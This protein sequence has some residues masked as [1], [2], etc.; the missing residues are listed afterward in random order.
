[1]IRLTNEW[2]GAAI[3]GRH[4]SVRHA[5]RVME[6]SGSRASIKPLA[7]IGMCAGLST[8]MLTSYRRGLGKH[9]ARHDQGAAGMRHAEVDRHV[10]GS[11]KHSGGRQR[12]THFARRTQRGCLHHGTREY[13][14]I[15]AGAQGDGHAA[16]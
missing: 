7:R 16:S 2:K 1:M 3:R 6:N 4:F 8:V 11:R 9:P 5:V 13:D 10:A 14:V 15:A 12:Q